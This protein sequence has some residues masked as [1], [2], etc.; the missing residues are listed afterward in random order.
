MPGAG[1]DVRKQP[2]D[3]DQQRLRVCISFDRRGMFGKVDA[4]I[5]Y[6]RRI[7]ECVLDSGNAACATHPDDGKAGAGRTRVWCSPELNGPTLTSKWGRTETIQ[8]QGQ[9]ILIYSSFDQATLDREYSP[10]SCIDDINVYLEAYACASRQARDA[11]IH[12]GT[13]AADLPYGSAPDE[14]LDLFLATSSGSAPLHIYIHGGYWQALSKDDSL[15]A[16]PMFQAH[17]SCFAATNYTLAPDATLEQIVQQNRRAI[18][19]L[20]DRADE[21]GYDRD[22]IYLSGSSAGAHLAAMMLLTDWPRYGLPPNLVKGICAVSGIYD[23]APVR[24]S[25]VNEPL[26]LNREDVVR[27]SPVGQA[28]LN[29]CPVILAYGDNE[30]SEFKR[31]TEDY[32]KFLRKQGVTTSF[33]EIPCRNHFDVIMDLA[34]AE[35]WL[36]QQVLRQMG[37]V[38][39]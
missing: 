29:R 20:Y 37:L 10:S 9:A 34:K 7:P 30:T 25:Y 18:G 1:L 27:N 5:D 14:R 38:G 16:A 23:L 11:A 3:A 19:W 22:R 35:T 15:F 24:L 6:A 4:R 2:R 28:L 8:S 12:Q 36:S 26:Q 17:G 32:R 21:W 31:Q 33:R 13:L 39:D